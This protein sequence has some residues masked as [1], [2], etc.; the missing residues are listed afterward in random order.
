V[1]PTG[2]SLS[3]PAADGERLFVGARDGLHAL[4][5]TSGRELW[6][7]PTSRR[8]AAVPVATGGAVYATCHDHHL[9]AL[10]AATGQELWRHEVER[11]IE[12]P[13]VLANCG[14]PARPCVLI[15]DRGGTLT[16]VARPLSAKEHE[17]AGHWQ[18][19]AELWGTLGR[20][21]KQAEALERHAQSLAE[22][23]CSVEERAAAWA[24]TA[25]A[26]EAEGEM[27]RAD[28]CQREEARWLR[29][30]IITLDVRHEGL[31]V[32][33]WSRLQLVAR[34]EGYGPARNLIVRAS[35]DEF[36]GQVMQTQRI[37]TLHAGRERTEWLDIR[38]LEYGPT[39]PLRVELEYLDQ[40]KETHSREHTIYIAVAQTKA[41]RRQGETISVTSSRDAERAKY[42]SRLRQ[43]L[44]TRF[45][46]DELRL[47]CFDLGVD[48]D[49]LPRGGKAN[50][51]LD[52]ICYLERRHRIPDL[53]EA[54]RASR[55]DISWEN[56]PKATEGS[57]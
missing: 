49:D 57:T 44:V 16:A 40:T 27:E 34:N 41:T 15:T 2:K 37:T 18:E 4:D 20:P 26:F 10:D 36:E 21:L 7:F 30:P 54:G 9:Y 42:L 29:Q 39:V 3:A 5:L 8:I 25:W 28:A 35:G 11:R 47:L 56:A 17:A 19:A 48:Y 24:D 38:P 31:V 22:Q 52:L 13:P 32:K 14:E 43:V 45:D 50:K 12:A 51:V 6:T 46:S 53:V 33:A 55:S 23:P 1:G